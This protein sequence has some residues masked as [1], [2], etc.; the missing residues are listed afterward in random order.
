MKLLE[1]SITLKSGRVIWT[2][3]G[4]ISLDEDLVLATHSGCKEIEIEGGSIE[5]APLTP[6]ERKEIRDHQVALW[7]KWAEQI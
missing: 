5:D 1:H 7:D 4:R 3:E 2:F 6:E